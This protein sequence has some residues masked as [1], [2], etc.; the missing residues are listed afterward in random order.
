[1][2]K[3]V[4][5]GSLKYLFCRIR[6]SSKKI[7]K[8]LGYLGLTL[9]SLKRSKIA[10][11]NKMHT[12]LQITIQNKTCEHTFLYKQFISKQPWKVKLL[13]K[14]HGPTSLQYATT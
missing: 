7:R 2:K 3:I 4:Y 12:G 9:D 1:M 8:H 10:F 5:C 6:K 14:F 11:E 13:C